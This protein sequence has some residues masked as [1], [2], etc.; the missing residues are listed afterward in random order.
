M[1]MFFG[2][3]G[4]ATAV[5]TP[6]K[7]N[8]AIHYKRFA[9]QLMRQKTA[10]VGGVVVCGTTGESAS[11]TDRERQ[12]LVETAKNVMGG[13]PVVAGA[14]SNDTR[15]AVALAQ[16][17]EKAGADALLVVTPYYNRPPQRGILL[18]YQRIAEAVRIPLIA[19]TVPSRTGV[20][21]EPDTYAQLS[22]L[23]HVVGVKEASGDAQKVKKIL[24]VTAEGF[25]VFC[26]CDALLPQYFE[27]GASGAISVAGNIIPEAV[28]RTCEKGVSGDRTGCEEE[29]QRIARLIRV[30]GCDVNPIPIKEAMRLMGTDNG[31]CRLP[32]CRMAT[33]HRLYLEQVLRSMNLL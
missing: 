2:P 15:K 24:E 27:Q 28:G 13:I 22:R 4:S 14:G 26:G 29:Y 19:Y 8:M 16:K 32:L 31:K 12:R 1:K 33:G 23:P 3:S 18:H 7:C 20:D 30:L 21:I 17:M 5:I 25:E 11:L 10:G 9:Q 6:M